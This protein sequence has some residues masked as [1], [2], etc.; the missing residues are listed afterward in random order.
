M[1]ITVKNLVAKAIL[2]QLLQVK[3]L[4]KHE[5]PSRYKD[6]GVDVK[7]FNRTKHRSGRRWT[8]GDVES[9]E[10]AEYEE[11]EWHLQDL[12]VDLGALTEKQV[13]AFLAALDAKEVH[14]S[15]VLAADLRKYMKVAK[16]G[17]EAVKA[18]TCYQAAWLL[19]IYFARLKH[20]IIFSEDEYGGDS[21]TGYYVND[22]VYH[23]EI[24]RDRHTERKPEYVEIE[25]V[26]VD[27]EA[28]R[29]FTCHL[30]RD[31]CVNMTVTEILQGVGYVPESKKLMEKLRAETV[32]F[33]AVR[34]RVG[35]QYVAKGVGVRDLDSAA[36]DD[37]DNERRYWRNTTVDL[38]HF[39][40]STRVV[41]DVLK[42]K[43]SSSDKGR[44]RGGKD[45]DPYRWHNWNMRMFSPGEDELVRHLEASDAT[46]EEPPE[47]EIPV[48]PLVPVFDLKRHE[49]MRVHINNLTKYKYNEQVS[50]YLVLPDRD[51]AMV[52]LL[53]D[54]SAN[55]FQDIVASKGQSMNVLAQG[56]PGTGKTATAEVF[57]EFKHRPLYSVQCSDL[58]MT[59][60]DVE[61]NLGVI[62]SRANR[63]NAVLLLDEADVYIR[64]RGTDFL[65]NAIVGAFLRVLEY[66]DCI[67]FMTTNLGDQVDDA[68]T[69][70]CIAKLTYKTPAPEDQ[71]RI[72]KILAD[73]NKID[74]K[75]AEIKR[76]VAKH[77]GFSG[78]DIK[79]TI[80]LASFIAKGK[81][82]T[83]E[84][85]EQAMI[86]KP[87]ETYK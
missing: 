72:W 33:Y 24:K 37:N 52:N 82:L 83:V 7:Y 61:H 55:E 38:E 73:L 78:R 50:N 3:I 81:P 56:S 80:K 1:I 58:G 12:D 9:G 85:I 60:K 68:I 75:E 47:F 54:H 39:G 79:N 4:S 22:V 49:R 64:K 18:R 31:N 40:S 62:M 32:R 65:Q 23:P 21:H 2:P 26:Y 28:R 57:A 25:M 84:M 69:S 66:A 44:H 86:F 77:H 48:L 46:I 35:V 45:V 19:E 71:A 15:R 41:V 34:E 70:R 6:D 36:S 42:E 63:W 74:L 11:W 20:H 10:D 30:Y 76:L 17:V 29:F 13:V 67:L 53:V 14:G 27:G 87:T 51:W 59:P 43:D 16:E 8:S 5:Q